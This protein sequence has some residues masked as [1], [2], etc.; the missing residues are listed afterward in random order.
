MTR[1]ILA[2]LDVRP[3]EVVDALKGRDPSEH[4]VSA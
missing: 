3:R 1:E 4:A 2:E